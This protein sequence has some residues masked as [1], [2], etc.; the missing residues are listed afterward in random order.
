MAAESAEQEFENVD[1]RILERLV[2]QGKMD[3]RVWEK[4]LKTLPDVS[5]KCQPVESVMDDDIDDEV[6]A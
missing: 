6:E 3:E 4:H 2:R 1:K 5:E